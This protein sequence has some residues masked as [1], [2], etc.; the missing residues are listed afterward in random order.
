MTDI[1][2]IEEISTLGDIDHALKRYDIYVGAIVKIDREAFI[3]SENGKVYLKNITYS[4]GLFKIID[5]IINNGMDQ[6]IRVELA[7]SKLEDQVKMMNIGMDDNGVITVVNTGRGI[8]IM[9]DKETGLYVPEV[10]FTRLKSSSN[11]DDSVKRYTGGRNGYGAA[12]ATIYSKWLEI[13][14]IWQ[15]KKYTQRF[16]DNCRIIKEPVIT[17]TK[18][19]Q[20]TKVVFLPDYD[21]FDSSNP[22]EI[23]ELLMTRAVEMSTIF[24]DNSFR[25]LFNMKDLPVKTFEQYLSSLTKQKFIFESGLLG[26]KKVCS[27]TEWRFG[28]W[29][30]G[31]PNHISFVNGINTYRGGKHVDGVL[32]AVIRKMKS[33]LPK[34]ITIG[35][36]STFTEAAVAKL[37]SIYLVCFIPNPGFGGQTKTELT[38]NVQI[39]VISDEFVKDFAISSGILELL[40]RLATIKKK[41]DDNKDTLEKASKFNPKYAWANKAGSSESSKCTLIIAEGE[42]AFSPLQTG[43]SFLGRDG[44]DYYGVFAIQGKILNPKK[45]KEGSIMLNGLLKYLI[46]VMGFQVG[47]PNQIVATLNYGCICVAAD[48]DADGFHINGLVMNFIETYWPTIFNTPGFIK[49]FRTPFVKFKTSSFVHEFYS[50]SE[51]EKWRSGDGKDMKGTIKFYKGLGTSKRAEYVEYFENL[52]KHLVKIDYVGKEEK[53]EDVQ[54]LFMTVFGKETG[55]RKIWMDS[56]A[57]IENISYEKTSMTATSYLNDMVS[58]HSLYNRKRNIPSIIDGLK[59]G[60]RKIIATLLRGGINKD[61]GIKA[62]SLA[63]R[64]IE[65]MDYHHGNVSLEDAIK[66]MAQNFIGTNMV[67]LL[68]PDGSYGDRECKK[69]SSSR[70]IFTQFSAFGSLLFNRDYL[71]LLQYA[72]SQKNL[73]KKYEPLFYYLP[74]PLVLMNGTSGIG[75]GWSSKVYKYNPSQIG[76][77]IKAHLAETEKPKIDLY[78]HKF[79]GTI[80]TLEKGKFIISGKWKLSEGILV[81]TEL[82]PWI[83]ITQYNQHLEKLRKL[84]V[85]KKKPEYYVKDAKTNTR[86]TDFQYTCLLTDEYCN[87]LRVLS[88][89]GI[90]EDNSYDY[91]SKS[92]KEKEKEKE[93]DYT[94]QFDIIRDFQLKAKCSTNNMC[95][96][97]GNDKFREYKTVY[98]IMDSFIEHTELFYVQLYGKLW[99]NAEMLKSIALS[100]KMFVLGVA[101]DKK[102]EILERSEEQIA[103]DIEQ[104]STLILKKD[105]SYSY[106]TDMP[107]RTLTKGKVLKLEE[108]VIKHQAELDELKK[109]TYKELWLSDIT[110]FYALLAK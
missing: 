34:N 3:V 91:K 102:I 42:S 65:K 8:P 82:P 57:G 30:A 74:V 101:V 87:K 62:G 99:A 59:L 83:T 95:L 73:T 23:K 70:Y 45:S 84:G 48:A 14:T 11:F 109:I 69:A 105:S 110:K 60:Q 68:E 75:T 92:V 36:K 20:R 97:D 100:K 88:A 98:D 53:L 51:Y 44:T 94:V 2:K 107:I 79:R 25:V 13:T 29:V 32:K 41:E 108:E 4:T 104:Y 56:R 40:K 50:E 24:N 21:F 72:D 47:N 22:A 18:E 38:T 17:D 89:D 71:G 64:V 106:L 43:R 80:E 86:H 77:Y 93:V 54:R 9:I 76:K 27:M 7:E 78:F 1:S 37:I 96:F 12:L 33:Y 5:E 85:I 52:V 103:T 28:L 49:V 55:D 61:D 16:E 6:K 35:A 58:L 90:E 26:D 39:P 81:I 63:S 15:G 31:E 19:L 66:L 46:E 10:A 67:N